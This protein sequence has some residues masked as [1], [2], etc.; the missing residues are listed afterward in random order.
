MERADVVII[1]G[2][3]I[4]AAVAFHLVRLGVTDVVLLERETLASGSTSRSAGGVRLQFADELNIRM[5]ER[6][7][8]DFE[9][10]DALI[11]EHVDYV[12]PIGF[13]QHGYLFLLDRESDVAV[14]REAVD[15]QRRLGV[16]T[17]WLTPDEALALVPQLDLDGVL[18]ATWNPREGY[19]S[20]EAVV[21]GLAAAAAAHGVRVVQGRGATGIRTEGGR[22]TGVETAEG[23]IA[24]DTV[25]CAAG[26]WSKEVGAMAG[27]EIPVEGI[28]HWMW[29][30]PES[31]GLPETTP[32]TIDF[33]SGFYFH[34]EGQGFVFG[35][36]QTTIEDVAEHALRR[37]PVVGEVPIAS[38]WWGYYDDSPD[39]NAIV[40]DIDAPGRL[41]IA[42]GF[43]GHGFQQAPAIGEHVAER[44]VGRTPTIDLSAFAL[45]RFARGATRTEHFVV[46]RRR[47]RSAR[48]VTRPA[49][50]VMRRGQPP[51]HHPYGQS[52]AEPRAA[53]VGAA[54]IARDHGEPRARS[55]R[56]VTRPAGRV[57]RRGQPPPHHPYGQSR[58]EPRAAHSGAPQPARDGDGLRAQSARTRAPS[59]HTVT[60]PAGRV[61][62]RGLSPAHHPPGQSRTQRA[63][64][65]TRQARD[66][67][68]AAR[69]RSGSRRRSACGCSRASCCGGRACPAACARRRR[70]C[71]R[72]GDRGRSRRAAAARRGSS[73]G[74]RRAPA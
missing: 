46:R 59:A 26:A 56:T 53:H 43:S 11:G 20:P 40:D 72:G 14:F 60:S 73:R 36:R 65:V 68:G 41:L 17:R 5:M 49:R 19:C 66:R 9:G 38:E 58:A 31:G 44:I 4:G 12:P 1:G 27:V 62:C 54:R 28:P 51:P 67:R 48:T 57:M 30:S 70:R 7:M 61:M 6:S 69:P 10:W 25:V 24:T 3:A 55:A 13:H 45:D 37:L 52:R 16:D 15:L 33:T 32:L 29:F 21:Q 74:P 2:G 18:A 64:S 22:I 39:H 35:G 8:P 63:R 71:G 34:R 23:V 42:T 47:A 50:R